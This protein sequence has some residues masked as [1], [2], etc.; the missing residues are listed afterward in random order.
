MFIDLDFK[1]EVNWKP[2]RRLLETNYL[3]NRG[4]WRSILRR[5]KEKL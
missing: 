2:K 5:K 3:E 1:S 4:K